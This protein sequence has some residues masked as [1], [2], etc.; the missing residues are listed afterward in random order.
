WHRE[1]HKR[2]GRRIRGRS[3]AWNAQLVSAKDELPNLRRIVGLPVVVHPIEPFNLSG[4]AIDPVAVDRG[5]NIRIAATFFGVVLPQ[6]EFEI[7]V[8]LFFGVERQAIQGNAF[9]VNMI[10]L[11]C[12]QE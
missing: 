2:S 1:S 9:R 6:Y 7:S 10:A 3:A 8:G 5:T 12:A 4:S 11:Q